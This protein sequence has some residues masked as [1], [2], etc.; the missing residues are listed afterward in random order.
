MIPDMLDSNT[1]KACDENLE[2]DLVIVDD[3]TIFT[4][5]LKRQLRR[6]TISYRIFNDS[7]EAL[8]FLQKARPHT[9]L[10]DLRMPV[11]DG[12]QLLKTLIDDPQVS[13]PK[14]IVYSSCLPPPDVQKTIV[15]M[16]ARLI[17]KDQVLKNQALLHLLELGE[18]D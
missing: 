13:P 15:S 8:H 6:S 1:A 9:L 7:V 12:V 10:V 14:T 11:L 16:Q 18:R 3:D 17:T 4:T 2:H 5:L